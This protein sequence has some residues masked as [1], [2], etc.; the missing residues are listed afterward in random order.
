MGR[1]RVAD[2]FAF[3]G[4]FKTEIKVLIVLK[5]P[6]C[7]SFGCNV[8][9]RGVRVRRSSTKGCVCAAGV[10]GSVTQ[11]GSTLTSF[12]F[13]HDFPCCPL[14]VGHAVTSDL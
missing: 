10:G 14:C 13:C 9:Q 8:V 1:S 11:E 4:I 5:V 6:G 2:L 12:S 7:S 3:M